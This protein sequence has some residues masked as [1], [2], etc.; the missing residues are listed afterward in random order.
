[1]QPNLQRLDEWTSV[2]GSPAP[3]G[4]SWVDT[5]QA[6]NFALYSRSATAVTL[7]CYTV[8]DPVTPVFTLKLDHFVNKT[9]RTWHC[10]VAASALGGATFYAYKVDGPD[11]PG[12]GDR[13]D[14]A[15]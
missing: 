11:N 8:D 14:A 7:L 15:K 9:G 1:M 12:N 13:F 6:Y 4:A 2:E 5:E 3:L 10:R